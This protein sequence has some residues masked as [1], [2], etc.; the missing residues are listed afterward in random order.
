MDSIC[1]KFLQRTAG[2]AWWCCPSRTVV[3]DTKIRNDF[4]EHILL[5]GAYAVTRLF[6]SPRI[7]IKAAKAE[8]FGIGCVISV[9]LTTMSLHFARCDIYV[10]CADDAIVQS[11]CE[12]DW[13]RQGAYCR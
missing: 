12:M 6:V 9:A 13:D 10:Y 7:K 8:A 5:V 4:Y 3:V 2:Y 1:A 11:E